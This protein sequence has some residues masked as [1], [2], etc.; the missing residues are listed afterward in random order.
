MMNGVAEMAG[1]M[2]EQAGFL[3]EALSY[4]KYASVHRNNMTFTQKVVSFLQRTWIMVYV[5]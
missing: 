2:N 1:Q 3:N 5:R 4:F